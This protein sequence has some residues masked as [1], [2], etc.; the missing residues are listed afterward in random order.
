MFRSKV[1][2]DRLAARAAARQS[3][4]QQSQ[5]P[6][7]PSSGIRNRPALQ[8]SSASS[9]SSRPQLVTS[10][11][12]RKAAPQHPTNSSLTDRSQPVTSTRPRKTALQ[13][14]STSS[15]SSVMCRLQVRRERLAASRSQPVDIANRPVVLETWVSRRQRLATRPQDHSTAHEPVPAAPTTRQDRRASVSSATTGR[16]FSPVVPTLGKYTAP[17]TANVDPLPPTP[18]APQATRFHDVNV[19]PVPFTLATRPTQVGPLKG[20]LKKTHGHRSIV[21]RAVAWMEGDILGMEI[22]D[23]WI[24][25]PQ[26]VHPNPDRLLGGLRGWATSADGETEITSGEDNTANHAEC[27][28]SHCNKR[29]LHQYARRKFLETHLQEPEFYAHLPPG[30]HL[31]T[32]NSKRGFT[33]GRRGPD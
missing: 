24:V 29:G 3:R 18:Q 12:P 4:G 1:V 22:V 27:R 17:P 13:S 32:F 28:R 14:R 6:S 16:S 31:G 30:E 9:L 8:P 5:A 20:I 23:R 21:K 19:P 15:A 26:D 33:F 25:R 7:Q 10:D 11:R 2:L